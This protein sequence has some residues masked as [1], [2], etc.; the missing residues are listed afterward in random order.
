M[1]RI[2]I[3]Y[4]LLKVYSKLVTVVVT[5]AINCDFLQLQEL[6]IMNETM[7]DDAYGALAL[8]LDAMDCPQLTLLECDLTGM[9]I[10]RLLCGCELMNRQVNRILIQ[11]FFEIQ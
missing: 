5:H 2:L 6:T 7:D 3:F 10:H 11:A 4:S 8:A 9:K 1:I